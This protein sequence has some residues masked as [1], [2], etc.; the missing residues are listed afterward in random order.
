MSI[1]DYPKIALF[2]LIP[3]VLLFFGVL[4]PYGKKERKA[5]SDGKGRFLSNIDN[6][7]AVSLILILTVCYASFFPQ[8]PFDTEDLKITMFKV[9]Y[10]YDSRIDNYVYLMMYAQILMSSLCYFFTGMCAYG[11][12]VLFRRKWLLILPAATNAIMAFITVGTN[13]NMNVRKRELFYILNDAVH[14]LMG[15]FVVMAIL[16]M[17]YTI[18]RKLLKNDTVPIVIVLIL[19][20]FH[21]TL[22]LGPLAHSYPSVSILEWGANAPLFPIGMLV[23][24]YKDKLI[25]KG[26]RSAVIYSIVCSFMTVLSLVVLFNL[27]Q[28]AI[29]IARVPA[30]HSSGCFLD[31]YG[32]GRYTAFIWRVARY[33]CITYLVLGLSICMLLVLVAS[34][35]R[36]GNKVTRFIREYSSEI[37]IFHF[38]LYLIFIRRNILS[39]LEKLTFKYPAVEWYVWLIALMLILII[40]SAVLAVILRKLIGGRI[41]RKISARFPH[42]EKEEKEHV[43]SVRSRRILIA[44]VALVAGVV[45]IASIATKDSSVNGLWESVGAGD[46]YMAYIQDDIVV[47]MRVDKETGTIKVLWGGSF[48]RDSENLT[49]V[50]YTSS[51]DNI[52]TSICAGSYSPRD[53]QR[54][55]SLRYSLG[56]LTFR[57][58]TSSED[59]RFIRSY[60]S[61]KDLEERLAGNLETYSGAARDP[62]FS[63][64]KTWVFDFEGMFRRNLVA[65]EITN[66]NPYR[67]SV[68][69][70]V[71][72]DIG[73]DDFR[74]DDFG[75]I[76]SGETQIILYT[77][78]RELG[79]SPVYRLSVL[80]DYVSPVDP[81]SLIEITSSEVRTDSSG[82]VE[83]VYFEY[84]SE[85]RGYDGVFVVLFYKD[86]DL[87]G[88]GYNY[89]D[90]PEQTGDDSYSF[91][92]D[93]LTEITD[94]DSY[95]IRIQ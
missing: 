48:A 9:W 44:A 18:L 15:I 67:I 54:K 33:Q 95:E 79:D 38:C 56:I 1:S 93:D 52:L 82:A 45:F 8:S 26:K 23:M 53:V 41:D 24:K 2:W 7:R 72:S 90:N 74:L 88:G 6:F 78:S 87:V 86:G 66:K 40:V 22:E 51:Y 57:R 71:A 30:P 31:G 70:V 55:V 39:V 61:D 49:S 3:V 14:Y 76:N 21:P 19:S 35:I 58:D 5:V 36:T 50:G 63:R 75:S 73:V 47:L 68:P 27:V 85:T 13:S 92:I 84:T 83:S 4:F 28:W 91:Y 46:K 89:V 64:G 80:D 11:N 16:Y 94:Y 62:S 77:G 37:V 60:S 17:V 29:R 65:I 25:P 34:R 81:N 12:R 20:L 59:I 10:Y 43:M 32:E 69:M 42:K